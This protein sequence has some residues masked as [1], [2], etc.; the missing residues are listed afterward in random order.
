V[1]SWRDG[2]GKMITFFTVY[3]CLHVSEQVTWY[4]GDMLV[5]S[6]YPSS[7]NRTHFSLFIRQVPLYKVNVESIKGQSQ[8]SRG[9]YLSYILLIKL[10]CNTH[11][12][13][14][15]CRFLFSSVSTCLCTYL[16][17]MVKIYMSLQLMVV[18]GGKGSGRKK[19][20][21]R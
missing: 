4:R 2:T 7:A 16:G 11:S 20:Q 14:I 3:V 8:L 1:T 5:E 13:R 9:R 6:L 17:N 19:G 18:Q 10:C 21:C 15:F 12:N